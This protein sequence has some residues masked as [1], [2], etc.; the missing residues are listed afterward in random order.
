M[1]FLVEGD[2]DVQI[3]VQLEDDAQY[4]VT[5]DGVSAGDMTTNMGGKLNVSVE[6]NE[7]TAVKVRIEKK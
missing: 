7:G 4:G 2:K 1:E 6:L 3:T 5:V